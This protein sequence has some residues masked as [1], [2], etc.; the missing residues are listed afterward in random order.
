[1]DTG[2]EINII[3]VRAL[4]PRAIIAT[5]EAMTITGITNDTLTTA[6]STELTLFDKPIKFQVITIALPLPV[7]GILGVDFLKQE[8]AELSFYHNALITSSRPITPVCFINH[9]YKAPKPVKFILPARARKKIE[10]NLLPTELQTGYI[11][12][13][14]TPENIFIGN[15]IVTNHD[16]KCYVMATNSYEEDA[17]IEIPP[18]ILE[19]FEIPDESEDFF[20]S[21]Y[22][23]NENLLPQDRL[24][25]I[26][27]ML[28]LDHL[29]EEEK[30]HVKKLVSEYSQLFHLPGDKLPA[31]GVLQ[32]TITTTDDA[33]VFI[34]QYR[35][36][37]V[38]REEI[39]RQVNKLLQ[40]NI[41]ED[42]TSPYNSPLWIV[43]KNQTRMEISDGVW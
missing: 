6:G 4:Q 25:Q 37:A 39:Q 9:E 30:E 5:H 1:M 43:P 27:D 42:S 34:K 17:E 16:Q 22:S 8:D 24:K 2:A 19:P 23:E 11:P 13:L 28:R 36:P 29:N 41:I 40:E 20:E 31:T 10:I 32:H 3:H 33:P 38:H 26:I 14:K 18:Q 15:A 12:R 7:N 21:D 35:Y